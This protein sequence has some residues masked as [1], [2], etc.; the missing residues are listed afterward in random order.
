MTADRPSSRTSALR[1]RVDGVADAPELKPVYLLTG[2]DGPKI[3]TA[4]ARLRGRFQPEAVEVVSAVELSGDAAVAL[5][6]AGS[7]FGDARLVVVEA[8][9][10]RKDGE[11]RRR[12]GGKAADTEAVVAYLGN[13][14]PETV[15]ALV[16]EETKKTSALWKAC[17]KAGEV[18]E[19]SVQK[20]DLQG[21]IAD[22]FRKGGAHAEPEACALLL[23]LVGEDL[24]AL[25]VEVDKL[26]TWAGGEPIGERE[27]EILVAAGGET[28]TFTLTDAWAA[29]DTARALEA[30]EILFE[31]SGRPR[32]DT[33]AR[34]A[35]ALGGHLG[36]LGAV[37]RLAEEGVRSQEAAGRLR[38][39][40]FYA[41]K[42]YGQAESFSPDELGTAIVRLAELDGALKG[43]SK[44]GPDLELQRALVDLTRDARA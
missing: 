4:I 16:A 26:T 2:S 1:A 44:L 19:Y 37:K 28:P 9:D 27:V 24:H 17:A 5:C 36:K 12:G 40:P 13:P 11:G 23:Q 29:R 41:R 6:N 21:W 15:L 7:L 8:I 30:S 42:L 33:A 34:L 20:R 35:G 31:L 10:G 3:E 14:A 43:Q 39:H 25:S 22:R 38:M 18:L 32:R